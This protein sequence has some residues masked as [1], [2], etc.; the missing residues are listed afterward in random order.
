[1]RLL[2]EGASAVEGLAPSLARGLADTD[3]EIHPLTLGVAPATLKRRITRAL[4]PAMAF[5]EVNTSLERQVTEVRPNV[6]WLFKGN[7]VYLRTLCRLRR[8]DVTLVN[9]NPDHPFKHFSRGS[10]N[11]NIVRSIPQFHLHLTYSNRIARELVERYP[12]I[13]VAVVPFGHEVDEAVYD[14]IGREPEVDRACFLGNP[15]QHRKRNIEYLLEAGVAV[16]VYGH[17]W[18]RF[19]RPSPRLR[20]SGQVVGDSM[21]RVLRCYRVQLNFFRPH[22]ADS[23]NMRTFEVPACGGIMLAEDSIE[24]R[25]FFDSGKEAFFFRT[26]RE[27]IDIARH[28]L[29]MPAGEADAVRRAARD[30]SMKSGYTYKDRAHSAFAAI[31]AAH[32]ERLQTA[33]QHRG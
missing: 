2:M 28:L 32:S 30:R 16:D 7:T 9:Y 20:I 23:H 4:V 3:C 26:P 10:G 17:R 6:L 1:M 27:M 33:G 18:D 11:S 24:H 31:R 22:N 25:A 5:P 13:R 21:L 19:L 29:A 14:R 15:D 12:G 8:Q